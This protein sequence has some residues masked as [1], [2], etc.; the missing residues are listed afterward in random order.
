M[1]L[2]EVEVLSEIM[3]VQLSDRI[4]FIIFSNI[5]RTIIGGNL[6]D[7]IQSDLIDVLIFLIDL[8]YWSVGLSFWGV[9]S[10]KLDWL[11]IISIL[12]V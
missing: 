7:F 4:G 3:D 8:S 6:D 10:S 11:S 5:R 2:G 12:G 1:G 9:Y